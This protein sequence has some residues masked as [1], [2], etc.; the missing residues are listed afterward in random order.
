M[1]SPSKLNREGRGPW[2]H[3]RVGQVTLHLFELGHGGPNVSEHHLI[4]YG[5]GLDKGVLQKLPKTFQG[6]L[7][8]A[9]W[10]VGVRPR[11]ALLCGL[12][13]PPSGSS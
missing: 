11:G 7:Q 3:L 12:R 4:F 13:V 2:V 8:E 9:F 10:A 1:G 6:H 5:P